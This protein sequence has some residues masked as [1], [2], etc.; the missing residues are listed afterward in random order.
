MVN[1]EILEYGS[2]TFL[3]CMISKNAKFR[4]YKDVDKSKK[5]QLYV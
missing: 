1:L 3:V 4:R 5:P 2:K